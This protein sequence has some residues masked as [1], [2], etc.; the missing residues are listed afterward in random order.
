MQEWHVVSIICLQY[1]KLSQHK[2]IYLQVLICHLCHRCI[3]ANGSFYIQP[4]SCLPYLNIGIIFTWN[5]CQFLHKMY[6][7]HCILKIFLISL[8][9]QQLLKIPPSLL[10]HKRMSKNLPHRQRI[11]IHYDQHRHQ[12]TNTKEIAGQSANGAQDFYNSIFATE[13]KSMKSR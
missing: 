3:N 2:H 11:P 8:L 1:I 13:I 6:I 10:C 12:H 5:Y 9:K 4:H 7:I